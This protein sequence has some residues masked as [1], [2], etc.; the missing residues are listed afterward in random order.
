[1][2][3]FPCLDKLAMSANSR[4][5]FD[6]MMVYIKRETKIVLEFAANLHNL[7]VQF[8]DRTNDRKLFISE[9]EGVPTSL[10]SYNCCQF[11]HQGALPRGQERMYLT[12]LVPKVSLVYFPFPC[13]MYLPK[14]D[15]FRDYAC[16]ISVI[17]EIDIE[18]VNGSYPNHFQTI[19]NLTQPKTS[20][21]PMA[22][23]CLQ[24][25]AATVRYRVDREFTIYEMM[26]GCFVWT[27]RYRVDTE[28]FMTPFPEGWLIWSTLWSIVL[29][30]R[31]QD[32]FLVINLSRKV[33]HYNL[34]SKTFNEIYDYGFNQLDD[35]QH[36]DADA[37][38][39]DDDDD[40]LLQQF[41][42]EHNVYEFISICCQ[43]VTGARPK[44][45]FVTGGGLS[46]GTTRV[47]QVEHVLGVV[48]ARC[49]DLDL[50]FL[51]FVIA[52]F[53][54]LDPRLPL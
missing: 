43:V 8:I 17:N 6:G 25:L 51:D 24:Q 52:T 23:P 44:T 15:F 2:A 18:P 40:E 54:K 11:P 36:D 41:Q 12:S 50:G 30:E 5:I 14:E 10:M 48:D 28:D 20:K 26:I 42:A 46:V 19:Y 33:V 53:L 32:Y 13:L 39:D 49:F 47:V 1:M 3:G 22:F 38:D 35:N 37:D 9:L 4:S 16:T 45:Q 27:V 31:E 29:G 7:G 34:I 21:R